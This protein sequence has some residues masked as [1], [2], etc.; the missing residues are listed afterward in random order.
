M[1]S[2]IFCSQRAPTKVSEKK[3][4]SGSESQSINR[5]LN[6][7]RYFFSDNI[8]LSWNSQTFLSWKWQSSWRLK[9]W[10]PFTFKYLK[11]H[12]CFSDLYSH[13]IPIS[14][15]SFCFKC[16][17]VCNCKVTTYHSHLKELFLQWIK[18]LVNY[19]FA[20]TEWPHFRATQEF[21]AKW[22]HEHFSYIKGH[23]SYHEFTLSRQIEFSYFLTITSYRFYTSEIIYI[24]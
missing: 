16:Q 4:I 10:I 19:F 9:I 11:L 13:H 7:Y 21:F 20:I 5:I 14:E 23:L 1:F 6:L 2:L 17:H 8:I 18:Q 24:L 15:M 3:L 22:T 12:L